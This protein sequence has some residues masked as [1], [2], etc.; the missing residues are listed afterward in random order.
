MKSKDEICE[1]QILQ[2][3][4]CSN[5]W[6][7][8]KSFC[9]VCLWVGIFSICFWLCFSSFEKSVSCH[10]YGP[11]HLA[12]SSTKNLSLL[13][14]IIEW[15]AISSQYGAE[16]RVFMCKMWNWKAAVCYW[17][18]KGQIT[19]SWKLFRSC[20]MHTRYD[21]R[22]ACQNACVVLTIPGQVPW[23]SAPLVRSLTNLQPTFRFLLNRI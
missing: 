11:C 18:I 8:G 23:S 21:Y 1:A 5:G 17:V 10:R 15:M 22:T 7:P 14:F 6:F 3:W 19:G 13:N 4:V 20:V 16:V 12:L 2:S 9:S